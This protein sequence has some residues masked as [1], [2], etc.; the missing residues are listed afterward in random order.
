ME[1]QPSLWWGRCAVWEG[2]KHIR[3][4]PSHTHSDSH[5][6][7][8]RLVHVSKEQH[9]HDS[10][11]LVS[12]AK[13][14]CRLTHHGSKQNSV[15]NTGFYRCHST[16]H[17]KKKQNLLNNGLI[18]FWTILYSLCDK[19]SFLHT[20]WALRRLRLS[21]TAL[22]LLWGLFQLT[23]G[24]FKASSESHSN[25]FKLKCF[26]LTLKN[27]AHRNVESTMEN[28]TFLLLPRSPVSHTTKNT[29]DDYHH[30]PCRIAKFCL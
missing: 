20:V 3:V 29:V 23:E 2:H 6:S 8:H 9:V 14:T 18:F 5:T 11:T 22:Q 4:W 1:S 26:F 12:T 15:E 27:Y 25:L 24:R 28:C 30:T 13:T 10:F 7:I 16:C 19:L 21:R 17:L